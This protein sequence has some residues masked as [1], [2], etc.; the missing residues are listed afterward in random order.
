MFLSS[1]MEQV[2]AVETKALLSG[3]ACAAKLLQPPIPCLTTSTRSLVPLNLSFVKPPSTSQYPITTTRPPVPP[4]PS[5]S[6]YPITTTRPPVLLTSTV[7]DPPPA[8]LQPGAVCGNPSASIQPSSPSFQSDRHESQE[9]THQ[10]TLFLLDLTK[11][12]QQLY[13]RNKMAFYKKIQNSFSQKGYNL[14]SEKIRKKLANMLTTY[15]RVKDR[16][17]ATGEGKI[18]WEYYTLMDELFGSS[19]IGT[20]PLGTI[21]ST[22][23]GLEETST[24]SMPTTSSLQDQPA[25][26]SMDEQPG[27]STI[28]NTNVTSRQRRPQPLQFLEAYEEHAERRTAV[29]ESLVRPDLER[30]WR[31]KERR[32]RSFEKKMVTSLGT[33]V[34]ELKKMGKRQEQ[35]MHLL[36]NPHEPQ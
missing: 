24:Q 9:I 20:A 30:W 28:P 5:T 25:G 14:S 35:I 36:Q 2:S 21:H 33:I 22:P 13:F 11:T 34:E 26:A 6:Q 10:M 19:G 1:V 15:K 23:L 31:L 16:R 8:T 4:P 3:P 12:H 27:T 18:T 7:K 32:R 29:L 17:R